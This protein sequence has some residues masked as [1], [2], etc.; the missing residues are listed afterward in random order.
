MTDESMP[1][2]PTRFRQVQLAYANMISA[3]QDVVCGTRLAP[4]AAL[5]LA[6]VGDQIMSPA[7]IRRYGYFIGTS[8]TYSLDLLADDRLIERVDGLVSSDR[9]RRPIK[10]TPVGRRIAASIRSH[11]ARTAPA[12]L[13]AS[14]AAR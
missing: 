6:F 9:R 12:R 7:D 5:I 11:L 8:L 3:V 2:M 10:L 4:Q 14:E 13:D 1:P